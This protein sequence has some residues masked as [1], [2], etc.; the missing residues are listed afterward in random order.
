M[1]K[2]AENEHHESDCSEELSDYYGHLE[3]ESQ[4][5]VRSVESVQIAKKTRSKVTITEPIEKI[6][7]NFNFPDLEEI[8]IEPLTSD[9]DFIWQSFLNDTFTKQIDHTEGK[10]N[11]MK[12]EHLVFVKTTRRTMTLTLTS[13]LTSY[14]STRKTRHSLE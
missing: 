12:L 4:M 5:S 9:Q 13:S 6:V 11:L 14:W 2:L 1:N 10:I 7:Q 3:T 8:P